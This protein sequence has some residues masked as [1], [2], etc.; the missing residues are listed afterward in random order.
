MHARTHAQTTSR[1]QRSRFSASAIRLEIGDGCFGEGSSGIYCKIYKL[2]LHLLYRPS[3]QA[4]LT[5]VSCHCQSVDRPS[6][7]RTVD[8]TVGRRSIT[9]SFLRDTDAALLFIDPPLQ[10]I[11]F[12]LLVVWLLGAA[13]GPAGAQDK[14]PEVPCVT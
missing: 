2:T 12:L 5:S 8:R 6:V 9:R 7:R 1:D 13:Q 11:V 14:A 3:K 4:G 10:R